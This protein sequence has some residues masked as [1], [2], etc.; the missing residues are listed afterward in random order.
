MHERNEGLAARIREQWEEMEG[1]VARLEDVVADLEGA[2]GLMAKMEENKM[3][4]GE[5][6]GEGGEKEGEGLAGMAGMIGRDEI[7]G[8]EGW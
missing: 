6:D 1:L 3:E 7:R 5:G 8:L 2:A 4:G